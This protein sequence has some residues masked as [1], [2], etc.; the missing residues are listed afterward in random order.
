MR[1]L[2]FALLNALCLSSE[3]GKRSF[4]VPGGDVYLTAYVFIWSVLSMPE[5]RDR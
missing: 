3:R 1:L 4:P 2:S 5:Q